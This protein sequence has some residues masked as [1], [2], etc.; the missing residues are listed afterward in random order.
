MKPELSRTDTASF[1]TAWAAHRAGLKAFLHARIANATEVDDVL[2]DVAIKAYRSFDTLHSPERVKA[3]LFQ[4]ANHA[5]IDLYRRLGREQNIHAEDLW[6]GGEP[7]D[8]ATRMSPCL[9]SLID[10][11]P[12]QTGQLLTAIDLQ[13]VPQKAYAEK[14]GI[15]Y[16]A[17]KSRVQRGRDDLKALFEDC[18]HLSFDAQGNIVDFEAKSKS[19]DIC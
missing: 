19:C 11:L 12:D 13:G 17:L 8:V 6:Y 18:C 5:L 4:I 3:W 16:S 10:D 7:Q 1:E 2:Q 15:G 9:R 14:L